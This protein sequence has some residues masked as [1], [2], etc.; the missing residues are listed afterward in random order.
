MPSVPKLS[1]LSRLVTDTK[2]FTGGTQLKNRYIR[3]MKYILLFLLISNASLANVKMSVDEALNKYLG[4]YNIESK[5]LYLSQKNVDK[6]SERSESKFTNRI[7]SYYEASKNGKRVYTAYLITHRLRTR[8]QTLFIVFKANGE[9]KSAEVI[10]FYEPEEYIMTQPWLKQFNNKKVNNMPTQNEVIRVSN[11]TI[12]YN[13][14]TKAIRRIAN[15]NSF[16]YD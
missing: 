10:A 14:T 3:I 2:A 9:M 7:F 16:I 4:Q 15:V 12:S 13:E 8:T 11:S 5:K 6:L 1:H